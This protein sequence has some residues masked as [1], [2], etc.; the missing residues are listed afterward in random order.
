MRVGGAE[1]PTRARPAPP[2]HKPAPTPAQPAPEASV[3]TAKPPQRSIDEYLEYL[4]RITQIEREEADRKRRKELGLP[5]LPRAQPVEPPR[6]TPKPR[7]MAPSTRAAA[8]A[9]PASPPEPPAEPV[10]SPKAKKPAGN[11]T[12]DRSPSA[13]RRSTGGGSLDDLFGAGGEGRVSVGKRT[14][15]TSTQATEEDG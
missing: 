1:P 4:G 3:T 9:A 5:P 2:E 8:P 13:A 6:P 14:R 12:V 15:R 11:D 7:A 10:S